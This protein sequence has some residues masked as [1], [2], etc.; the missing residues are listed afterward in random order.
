MPETPEKSLRD[1]VRT[2]LDL[3]AQEGREI[4]SI[5]ALR[6]KVQRGSFTAITAYVKEW[7]LEHTP[8]ADVKPEGFDEAS[9]KALSDAVWRIIGPAVAAQKNALRKEAEARLAIERE[10]TAKLVVLA[11]EKLKEAEAME[12]LSAE[13]DAEIRRLR[14]ENARLAGELKS[15]QQAVKDAKADYARVNAALNKAIEG[16]V[17]ATATLE[18]FKKMF[19]LF[20]KKPT[21]RR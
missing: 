1:L 9:G 21:K 14:E 18:A 5:R 6:A 15:A 2:E 3:A 16:E 13:K 4:P 12:A 10:E 17:A 19:P 11:E 7:R 8:K 20:E